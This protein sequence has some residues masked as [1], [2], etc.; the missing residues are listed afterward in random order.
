MARAL[1]PPQA[2]G[3]KGGRGPASQH[4]TRQL[5]LTYV[6]VATVVV[7]LHMVSK[8]FSITLQHCFFVVPPVPPPVPSPAPVPLPAL[9]SSSDEQVPGPPMATVDWVC[10]LQKSPGGSQMS[11]AVPPAGPTPAH[12]AKDYY[13]A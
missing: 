4:N 12:V 3:R 2:A 11:L 10:I 1:A 9:Q 5:I 6:V 13:Q 8:A 7:S